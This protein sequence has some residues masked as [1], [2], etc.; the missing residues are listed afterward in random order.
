ME[1]QERYIAGF[2]IEAPYVDQDGTLEELY[3]VLMAHG[4]KD[5]SIIEKA[6]SEITQYILFCM[7]MTVVFRSKLDD[8]YKDI[9][10]KEEE[11]EEKDWKLYLHLS[12]NRYE[13]TPKTIK[14]VPYN[15]LEKLIRMMEYDCRN[16]SSLSEEESNRKIKY[17]VPYGYLFAYLLDGNTFEEGEHE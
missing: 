3:D 1:F 9:F 11:F 7:E 15:N 5:R 16:L 13:A 2:D 12:N 8:T 6:C 10:E 17:A 14:E 4:Q